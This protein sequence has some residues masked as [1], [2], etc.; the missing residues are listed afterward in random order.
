MS[1]CGSKRASFAVRTVGAVPADGRAAPPRA[2]ALAPPV[3]FEYAGK[4]SLA[5]LGPG[6]HRIYRFAV[7]GARLE[8]DPRDAGALRGIPNLR[9]AATRAR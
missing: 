9:E 4:T 7:P 5:V 3:I 2:R 8:I 6:T 1:C